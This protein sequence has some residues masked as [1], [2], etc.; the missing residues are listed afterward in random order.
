MDGTLIESEGLQANWLHKEAFKAA[1]KTVFGLD[2]HL[3]VVKHHGGTDPLLL[4]KVG[5]FPLIYL[6]NMSTNVRYVLWKSR[7]AV[8]CASVTVSG[9]ALDQL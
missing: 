5:R 4:L 1:W 8:V 7:L 6:L 3:D 2:T 9:S